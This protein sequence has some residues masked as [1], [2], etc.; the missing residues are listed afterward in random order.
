MGLVPFAPLGRGFLT[1]RVKRAEEYPE[2]D[3]RRGDP[4][5][6]GENFDAHVRG[7]GD[8]AALARTLHD[9][10]GQTGTPLGAPSVPVATTSFDLDTIAVARAL[11]ATGKA[12]GGVYQ[13][14]I[15]RHETIREAGRV[16]PPAMGVATAINFQPT[17]SGK[18]AV[19]GDFVLRAAE[20]NPVI[21]ALQAAGIEVTAL[22]SHTLDEEPRLFFMH[23]WANDDAIALARGLRSAIDH[24]AMK[25][26]AAPARGP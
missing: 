21:R 25:L 6:Q 16:V 7:H 4:R 2:G 18:A 3:F 23:F 24:T 19:T 1:G 13:V 22:H 20:V 10:L 15:P 5:Y 8:A 9:A 14:S 17:G 11:G 12:N 26:A